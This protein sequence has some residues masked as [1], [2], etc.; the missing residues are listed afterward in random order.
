MEIIWPVRLTL[1]LPPS[2][3][4]AYRDATIRGRRRRVQTTTVKAYKAQVRDLA[5][6]Q[7]ASMLE[8]E[9]SLTVVV[10]FPDRRR[11]LSNVVKVLEDSL[12]GICYR[13]D[14]QIHHLELFKRYDR[15]NPRAEIVLQPDTYSEEREAA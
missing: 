3:N 2:V 7:R 9:L 6:M 10:Y 11:D 12:K 15:G 8:G 1:P 14:R 5:A 13:D 4:H